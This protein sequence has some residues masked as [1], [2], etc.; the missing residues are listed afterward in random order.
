MSN[1]H[2]AH[3][4]DATGAAHGSVQSYSIGFLLSIICTIAAYELVVHHVLSGWSLIAAI[5]LL[6]IVQLLVQLLFFLHLNKGSKPRWNL[7][8][9]SF[10]LIL[11]GI[12]VIG[13]LWIMANL[14]YNMDPAQQEQFIIKDEGVKP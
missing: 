9:F 2:A 3:D 5:C 13:S 12:L 1:N 10:M 7:I 14:N 11:V 6:A 8:V 4:I